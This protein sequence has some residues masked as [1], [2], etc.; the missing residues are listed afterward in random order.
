M[1]KSFSLSLTLRQ[2]K[3]GCWYLQVF[4]LD[5][6]AY[7]ISPGAHAWSGVTLAG[8]GSFG[9]LWSYIGTINITQEDIDEVPSEDE[10][11]TARTATLPAAQAE[12]LGSLKKKITQVV[13]NLC[14]TSEDDSDGGALISEMEYCS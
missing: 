7:L 10:A 12:M 9:R 1:F 3:L 5:I 14:K 13:Q 8:F 4:F 2:N 11:S 6:L